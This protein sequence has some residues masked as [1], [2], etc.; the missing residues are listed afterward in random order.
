MVPGCHVL[1]AAVE[2]VSAERFCD[3]VDVLSVA[4]CKHSAVLV[5]SLFGVRLGDQPSA[6]RHV[7]SAHLLVR[8]P[9]RHQHFLVLADLPG[10]PPRVS[11]SHRCADA[12]CQDHVTKAWLSEVLSRWQFQH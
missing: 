12:D 10:R 8:R 11:H 1:S 7:V 5:Q 9:R 2:T 4:D 3:G 6:R